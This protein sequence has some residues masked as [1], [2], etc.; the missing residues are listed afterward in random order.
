V[1]FR[2]LSRG[3]TCVRQDARPDHESRPVR[4]AN[5]LYDRPETDEYVLSRN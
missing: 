5:D 3:G 1:G 2:V 4:R